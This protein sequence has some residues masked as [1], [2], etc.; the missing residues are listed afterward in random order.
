M[1]GSMGGVEKKTPTNHPHS[2]GGGLSKIRRCVKRNRLLMPGTFIANSMPKKS[3]PHRTGRQPVA[4]GGH[5]ET[6]MMGEHHEN[7]IG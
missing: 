3:Y 1:R 6:N 7:F 2:V 5:H 4:D